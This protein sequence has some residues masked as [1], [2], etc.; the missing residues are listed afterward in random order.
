MMKVKTMVVV[1]KRKNY[2]RIPRNPI[3]DSANL[4]AKVREELL[5]EGWVSDSKIK[6]DTD[7]KI[8][9]VWKL[10]IIRGKHDE[11]V[12]H[13][14]KFAFPHW[15][16]TCP[17]PILLPEPP[18]IAGPYRGKYIMSAQF[19]LYAER[20]ARYSKTFALRQ[21]VIFQEAR[22]ILVGFVIPPIVD[23]ILYLSDEDFFTRWAYGRVFEDDA[24]EKADV[25]L[26]PLPELE[27]DEVCIGGVL[28]VRREHYAD[29]DYDS[30]AE[31]SWK[32]GFDDYYDGISRDY[33]VRV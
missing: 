32:I 7:K 33:F 17:V 11:L 29:E 30:D 20:L 3:E 12:G 8:D 19:D 18:R 21:C 6:L 23:I 2:R 4:E 13:K 5:A 25:G 16:K 10:E 24:V 1:K 31:G 14:S 27:D 28:E 22:Q 15:R 26:Q 9:L